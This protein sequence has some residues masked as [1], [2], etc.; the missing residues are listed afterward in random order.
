M[1]PNEQPPS[2]ETTLTALVSGI[3][4][5]AQ[6]LLKQQVALLKHDIRADLRQTR[7]ALT[8]LVSG[9]VIAA[10]GAIVLSFMLVYLLYWLVPAIPL[11]GCF[12]LVGLVVTAVGVILI[13][14]GARQFAELGPPPENAAQA[15]RENLRWTTSPTKSASR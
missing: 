9:G 3:V 12:A 11:W 6:E 2:S 4:S 5:D 8:S 7:E 14:A 1:A 13:H 10:V 15:M